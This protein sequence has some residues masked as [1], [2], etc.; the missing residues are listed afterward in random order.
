MSSK[1]GK[2]RVLV[3][4]SVSVGE[5]DTD[6]SV[7]EISPFVPELQQG[8]GFDLNFGPLL[9]SSGFSMKS[10]SPLVNSGLQLHVYWDLLQLSASYPKDVLKNLIDP[11]CILDLPS[12]SCF[13]IAQETLPGEPYFYVALGGY[14]TWLLLMRHQNESGTEVFPFTIPLVRP[15]L[16]RQFF[17]LLEPVLETLV[18]IDLPDYQ[19]AQHLSGLALNFVRLFGQYF[20]K[21]EE[22][23]KEYLT[24]LPAI[25]RGLLLSGN[26]SDRLDTLTAK[27][28]KMDTLM[29]QMEKMETRMCSIEAKLSL[30]GT[31]TNRIPDSTPRLV[32]D[33]G[34]RPTTVHPVRP[35]PTPDGLPV[36]VLKS[37]RRSDPEG[38]TSL[39]E[40]FGLSPFST[41]QNFVDQRSAC[42]IDQ[43][44]VE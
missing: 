26:L 30:F 13:R 11:V 8:F 3:S 14:L 31:T 2:I 4:P 19:E 16:T 10:S 9:V 29:E 27:L 6:M 1:G 28:E 25:F 36:G 21:G 37:D 17:S 5:S 38:L 44:P 34:S 35:V 22:R 18:L 41:D 33:P 43:T 42:Q 12:E 23:S 20:Q 32:P 7:T 24:Y 39:L 40:R 15:E